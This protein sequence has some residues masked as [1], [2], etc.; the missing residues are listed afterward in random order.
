MTSHI[1][2]TSLNFL[3]LMIHVFL[4]KRCKKLADRREEIYKELDAIIAGSGEDLDLL[5]DMFFLKLYL[6]WT[7]M[8]RA[9]S[10][11]GISYKKMFMH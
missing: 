2:V 8:K 1:F 9:Q 4:W 6:F 3:I 7:R 11:S 10:E 5:K